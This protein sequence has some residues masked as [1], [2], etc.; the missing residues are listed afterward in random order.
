M[1]QS[2]RAHKSKKSPFGEQKPAIIEF[3]GPPGA[4]KTTNCQYFLELLK[5]RGLKVVTR[6]DI[7]AYVR[8]MGPVKKYF[9][10]ARTLFFRGHLIFYYTISL[11][12]V[13]IYS[14]DSIYRYI[15][16]SVYK[17]A[18]D[19]LIKNSKIEL[20][21]LDQWMIQE[22]WSAT[23]F[24]DV[25]YD[26]L[27]QQLSKFYFRTDLVFYF[28]ID[29]A[30]ASARIAQR[31]TKLS[32]FDNMA[33]AQRLRELLK[34]GAYLLQLFEQ[35]DCTH[36]YKFC[37]KNSPSSNA[38]IFLQYL[39]FFVTASDHTGGITPNS[40]KEINFPAS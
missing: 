13:G 10:Y 7:E 37:S 31:G 40:I 8:K 5:A 26:T 36:K 34:Y 29:L 16:L 35:S 38:L 23:I 6:Q 20:V 9:L 25:A 3:V 17:L 33:P 2:I 14:L 15:R 24:K 22:L 18:L 19:Q 27:A 21:L 1:E 12:F 30:T 32:R 11:A 28:S 39:S 4:G